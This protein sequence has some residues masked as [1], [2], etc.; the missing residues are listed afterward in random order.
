MDAAPQ[1]LA[2]GRFAGREAFAQRIRDAL[3]CAA[4]DGWREIMLCDPTFAD[5]PLG[6]SA[7]QASLQAWAQQGR[8]LRLLA[9]H[10]DEVHRRHARFVTWRTTWTHLLECRA[11]RSASPQDLPSALY[12][13]TWVLQ[14]LDV[15]NST[16]MCGGE[17]PRRVLLGQ[18]LDAWWGQ[19]SP[20]FSAT[21]LGL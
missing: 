3:A 10:Y 8:R 5:W 20:A 6:E 13:P 2:A 14:R 11:C 9:I 7:V 4:R 21:V 15:E 12:S 19:A 18:H 17:A 16:G 1:V